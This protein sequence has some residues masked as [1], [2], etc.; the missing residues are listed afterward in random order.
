LVD[1]DP[2]KYFNPHQFHNLNNPLAHYKTTGEEIWKQTDG[3][4]THFV[5]SLG[6]SGTIMG[7]GKILREKNPK[8]KII[9]AHPE[10]GHKIQGLKNMGEA[11]VPKIYDS[12]KVDQSII[13]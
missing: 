8:I 3:R 2:D 13:V 1:S 9:E 6:T 5:A 12:S 11:I 10:K 7:V 4:V